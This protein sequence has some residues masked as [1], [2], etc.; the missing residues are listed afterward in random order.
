MNIPNI[1]SL[2][3]KKN[4]TF[5]LKKKKNISGAMTMLEITGHTVQ[6]NEKLQIKYTNTTI[7][8][9]PCLSKKI[10]TKIFFIYVIYIK[11]NNR[12]KTER[13]V[14]KHKSHNKHTT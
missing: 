13:L 8:H 9:L 2:R 5:W 1:F 3:N 7:Q 6:T 10:C 14:N 4:I 11:I 12:A